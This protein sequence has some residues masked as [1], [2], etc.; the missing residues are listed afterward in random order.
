MLHQ[1][2]IAGV[3]SAA[4]IALAAVTPG[5]AQDYPTQPVKVIVPYSAGGGTDVV[6]RT[7]SQ[8]LGER[9]GQQF[10]VE[11][12]G[13]ANATIGAEAAAKSEP[14]GYTLLVVSGVP[15]VL[16]QAIYEDLPYDTQTDF[17]PINMFAALPMV[18]V[19]HP[20]VPA[21]TPEE[22]VA[23]LK[24]RPGEL[25]YAGSDQMT[26]FAMESIQRDTGTDMEHIPY[27]GAGP[28]LTDLLGG[29]V[30]AML[31]S[32]NS[33]LPHIR[34][35][36]LRAIAVTTSE[37]S[38]V[39]EDVPTIAETIV[40][41]YELT[42]WFGLLAPSGT[43]EDIIETLNAQVGAAVESDAL[44]EQFAKLGIEPRSMSAEEF[45]AFLA[46]ELETWSA[47]VKDFGLPPQ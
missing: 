27:A 43:P 23:Y 17:A 42:A 37:R 8:H 32:L 21:E 4:S 15:F 1:K 26:Y 39:L 41:G 35:G 2:M 16:N 34:A 38:P 46:S 44:R 31:V 45:R 47:A 3:L 33:S 13:G 29:H 12:R 28:G 9:L 25:N 30:S 19:V 18:L 36:K 5:Q 20:D 10:I 40:P 11:N 6:T 22:L 7:L 24:A 14:D